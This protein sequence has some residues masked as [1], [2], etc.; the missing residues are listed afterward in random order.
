MKTLKKIGLGVV[1]SAWVF[2]L[3]GCGGEG[4][5]APDGSAVTISPSGATWK[6]AGPGCAGT[7]FNFHVFN[8]TVRN[9][10]GVPLNNVDLYVTLDLAANNAT[11]AQIMRLYDDPEWQGGS[12]TLPQNQKSTPYVTKTDGY[13]SKR[14]VVGVDIGGCTYTGSLNVYSGTAFGSASI[15]VAP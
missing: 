10:D 6:V 8:I 11:T 12:S 14:L 5:G 15:S 4:N 2:A 3:S 13:G 9:S 1:V 7:D